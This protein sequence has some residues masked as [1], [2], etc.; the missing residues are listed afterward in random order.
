MLQVDQSCMGILAE[1][2]KEL[3]NCDVPERVDPDVQ[4]ANELCID[5]PGDTTPWS[6]GVMKEIGKRV[7]GVSAE[8]RVRLEKLGQR[9][10]TLVL[11]LNR[12]GA[13]TPGQ[14][15]AAHLAEVSQKAVAGGD[16][17]KLD[18]WSQAE[19]VAERDSRME[20]LKSA[21]LTLGQQAAEELRETLER[22]EKAGMEFLVEEIRAEKARFTQFNLPFQPSLILRS[23]GKTVHL[24]RVRIHTPLSRQDPLEQLALLGLE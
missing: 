3:K 11:Q 23:I 13:K 2:A 9:Y 5:R 7:G 6:L 16:I 15:F 24:I 21:L 12:E 19:L 1:I 17:E 20:A 14:L 22:Y 10:G 4:L 18:G 8:K